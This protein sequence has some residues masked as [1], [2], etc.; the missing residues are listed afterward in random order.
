MTTTGGARVALLLIEHAEQACSI[1]HLTRLYRE[2]WS[3][4]SR[5]TATSRVRQGV[6][7]LVRSG[8]VR[9]LSGSTAVEIVDLDGLAARALPA[10]E[11]PPFDPDARP[12]RR[13]NR[14][15][16]YID[17]LWLSGSPLSL[18][19]VIELWRADTPADRRKKGATATSQVTDAVKALARYGV[20]ALDPGGRIV[21]LHK[22]HLV[23]AALAWRTHCGRL[24][25]RRCGKVVFADHAEASRAV[26]DAKIARSLRGRRRRREQRAYRCDPCGGW[27]LT[28]QED[29]RPL[30]EPGTGATR[31]GE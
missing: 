16:D 9:P 22:P 6:D 23:R 14:V 13:M 15:A 30:P 4:P 19:H 5:V 11:L 7:N 29:S 20:V 21:V 26:V 27:H 12:G 25:P 24:G 1:E 28:S 18:R 8:L 2:R 31:K 17:R 3:A 10:R